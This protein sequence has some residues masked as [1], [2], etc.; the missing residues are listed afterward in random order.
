MGGRRPSF[1][2]IL[3]AAKARCEGCN[4]EENLTINHKKPLSQGGSNEAENLEIL[5]RKCHNDFHGT[6]KSKR[7]LR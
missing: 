6:G 3:K 4:T 5:C 2:A 1:T 7:E